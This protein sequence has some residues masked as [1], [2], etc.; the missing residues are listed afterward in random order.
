MTGR[1]YAVTLAGLTMALL[2]AGIAPAAAK[3]KP[4][5][6]PDPEPVCAA[7]TTLSGPGGVEL[8]CAW[9]PEAQG[10]EGTVAVDATGEVASLAIAVRDSAPGDYCYLNTWD[11][12]QQTE[13]AAPFDL[14]RGTESYWE[15]PAN[16]CGDRADLNGAPVT[17]SVYARVKRGTDVHVVLE[18]P[19]VP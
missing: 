2:V 1:R 4:S 14:V 12:P 9:T 19:P 7:V 17:V 5:P 10:V 16:W 8:E 13:F 3:P 11:K 15:S 18:P 6:E